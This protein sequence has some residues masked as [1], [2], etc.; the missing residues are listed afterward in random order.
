QYPTIINRTTNITNITVINNR[1][2]NN[3]I[4]VNDVERVTHQRVERLRVAESDRPDRTVVKGNQVVLYKPAVVEQG[5]ANA[6]ANTKVQPA[7]IKED[8][9]QNNKA[10][11]A[12]LGKT[13]QNFNQNQNGNGLPAGNTNGDQSNSGQPNTAQTL[14]KQKKLNQG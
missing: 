9:A 1:I 6:A 3:S 13:K 5:Q 4:Q 11:F 2:V 10:R 8:P 12:N 14:E 7:M